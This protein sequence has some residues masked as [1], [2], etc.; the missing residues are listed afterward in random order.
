MPLS[1]CTWAREGT[2]DAEYHDTVWG[3]P[4]YDDRTLFEYLILEGA[5]AG[6]SWSTI[7]K[8][9]ASYKEAFDNFDPAIVASYDEAKVAELLENEGIIRNRLKILSAIRNA[10]AFLE[11]QKECGSFSSYIWNFVDGQPIVNTF[12][13]INDIPS[14]TPLSDTISKDLKK[15]GMNFVGSTIMY[16]YMQ[17]IGMVN[18]HEISCFR[19]KE[20]M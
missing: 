19:Y 12:E 4:E 10:K 2:L 17:A 7:L 16:A 8:K 1:R 14:S 20:V 9:Q 18:D 6:L 11:I 3:V 15:R 13:T 5:Q